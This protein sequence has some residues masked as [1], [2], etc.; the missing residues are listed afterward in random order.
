MPSISSEG[1]A[2]SPALTAAAKARPTMASNLRTRV[3]PLKPLCTICQQDERVRIAVN[4]A[5]WDQQTGRRT[6]SYRADAVALLADFGVRLGPGPGTRAGLPVGVHSVSRHADHVEASWRETTP[7]AAAASREEP[8]FTT[9]FVSVTEEA[10]HL[11]MKALRTLAGR[12]ETMADKDLITTAKLGVGASVSRATLSLKRSELNLTA[13]AIFGL[14]S[15]HAD[16]PEAEVKNVTP[17]GEL[18]AE[19]AREREAMLLAAGH[20]P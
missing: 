1:E 19:I 12:V 11:G 20:L 9:D 15:G 14:A 6:A 13:A 3:A 16:I 8:L 18:H 10:A 4:N 2:P 17:E 7:A 5:I